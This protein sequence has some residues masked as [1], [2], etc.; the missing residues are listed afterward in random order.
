M[1]RA[2]F[3]HFHHKG[4]Y[5]KGRGRGFSAWSAETHPSYSLEN[6]HYILCTTLAVMGSGT[7]PRKYCARRDR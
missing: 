4:E 6:I 7:I 1:I 2:C 3:K 5:E